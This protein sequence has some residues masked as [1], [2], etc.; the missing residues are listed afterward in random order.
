[1]RIASPGILARQIASE[2]KIMPRNSLWALISILILANSV[3]AQSNFSASS[4][5]G[6]GFRTLYSFTGGN[7]GCCIYGGLAADRT[8]SVYGVAYSGRT[9]SDYGDLFKL[10]YKGQGYSFRV[11]QG[12]AVAGGG[13]ITTPTIDKAG[14]VFGVCDGAGG[15]GGYGTLWEYSHEGK[16]SILRTFN[17][18]TD[19]SEPQDSVVLDKSGNI[20]GT[21]YTGGPG[22]SGTL[23]EYSFAGVFTLLHA[24]TDGDDGGLLPAG[25]AID[26]NGIV[27]GTTESGPNCYYCGS[28][29]VWSYDPASSI[30]TTV[31]DFNVSEIVGP[32]S[33]LAVDRSGNLY[34]TGFTAARNNCG[35]V[36]ELQASAN[37][38]PEVLYA[39]TKDGSDGCEPFGRVEL[40][41]QGNIFGATSYGG[42][43]GDG[44]I[45]ELTPGIGWQE[46][47]LHN[48]DL[49]DGSGPQSGLITNG[50]NDWFGTT[51]W[52]G[53][54]KWGTVFEISGVH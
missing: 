54:G 10:T 50:A 7:D 33:R 36:Y 15:A 34:G 14:N 13:C 1:L 35:L 16:F 38:A 41:V 46:R 3:F 31:Q 48:F 2:V 32:M 26:G 24:F 22:G 19:G 30:F 44:T 27:W 47:I 6:I 11:L 9:L 52:G 18:L 53:S 51:S 21:T 40:D 8:G 25:P 12:L 42:A 37:Y 4:D 17:G 28:G 23:W 29:T 20:Y 5:P 45:Y 39:F 43:H 49:S